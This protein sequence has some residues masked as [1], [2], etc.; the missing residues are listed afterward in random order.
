VL[1]LLFDF[2]FLLV[3]VLSFLFSQSVPAMGMP[4][5]MDV[6]RDA[7]GANKPMRSPRWVQ[8]MLGFQYPR[9]HR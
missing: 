3:A 6:S 8:P 5:D 1:S 9:I 7:G 2:L 4:L